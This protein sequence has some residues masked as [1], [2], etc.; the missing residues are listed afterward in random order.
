MQ[1]PVFPTCLIGFTVQLSW[2]MMM[3]QVGWKNFVEKPPTFVPSGK[4]LLMRGH[5]CRTTINPPL[6][7]SSSLQLTISVRVCSESES[8]WELFWALF[9]RLFVGRWLF[10]ESFRFLASMKYGSRG[11]LDSFMRFPVEREK[12]EGR[13]FWHLKRLEITED[14]V[15]SLLTL[16]LCLSLSILVYHDQKTEGGVWMRM[17]S[18]IGKQY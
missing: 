18:E 2:R 7:S 8:T 9:G 11:A 1:G 12:E 16:Y 4:S 13:Y 10:Y 17:E 5:F 3:N 6:F 14:S 15:E